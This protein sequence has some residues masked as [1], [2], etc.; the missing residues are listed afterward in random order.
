MSFQLAALMQFV[1]TDLLTHGDFVKVSGAEKDK[2]S[3]NPGCR[4]RTCA[5]QHA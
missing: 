3:S 1:S 4:P 2:P 5:A